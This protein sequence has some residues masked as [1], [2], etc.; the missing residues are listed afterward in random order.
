MGWTVTEIFEGLIFECN[1]PDYQGQIKIQDKFISKWNRGI[2]PLNY[3]CKHILAVAI[4]EGYDY[5][6]II[7]NENKNLIDVM[8]YQQITTTTETPVILLGTAKNIRVYSFKASMQSEGSA[9]VT[10]R[11]GIGG[12]IID[13]FS[14]IA[15]GDEKGFIG[16]HIE[17]I[18]TDD[19]TVQL[20]EAQ[21]V[22]IY[23]RSVLI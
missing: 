19:I 22:N 1:C 2:V 18:G 7:V 20:S 21:T 12:D 9:D 6:S 13:V 15:R 3:P 16:N 23:S 14:L 5:M 10:I 4:K 8:T 11:D 17:W